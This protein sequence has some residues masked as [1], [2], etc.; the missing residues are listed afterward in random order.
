MKTLSIVIPA[1]N[2]EKYLG[3]CLESC[4]ANKTTNVIEVI[5]IDNASTDGTA[6]LAQGYPGV[7]VVHEPRKGLTCARERGLLEAKGDLVGYIDAD[8]RVPSGWFQ[9]MNEV[10]AAADGPVCLSGPYDYY[11][12]GPLKRVAVHIWWTVLAMPLYWIAGYM[13]VGGNFVARKDALQKI[14]GFDTDI[15]FYGEDTNIARRLHAVGKVK[16]SQRFRIGTSARRLQKEGLFKI[17]CI[18]AANFFSEAILHK[19]VTKEYIDIR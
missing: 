12:L 4:L 16:F 9:R 5:V 14:G 8:T 17:A 1:Y 6:A 11:D 10:F 7:R 2:E 13:V 19:P 18:Y 15:A 3:A